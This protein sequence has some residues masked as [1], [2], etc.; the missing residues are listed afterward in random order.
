MIKIGCVSI[1]VSHPMGIAN[2]LRDNCMDMRYTYMWDKGFRKPEE[3]EW[4]VKHFG[5][6]AEVDEIKD[7]VDKVDVGFIHSC[8]WEKHLP[9]AMPFIEAGKPVYLDK[10]VVGTVADV[11]KVRELIAGGAKII[12][13]SSVRYA[14]E[15]QNF[16][17]QPVEQRGEVLAA[18]CT[19]GTNE[20]DY[21][22]HAVEALSEIAGAKAKS[23]K[24]VG[25]TKNAENQTCEAFTIEF[26]NGVVGTYYSVLGRYNPFHI[27]IVTTTQTVSFQINNGRIMR[28]LMVKVGHELTEGGAMVDMETLLNCTEIMLCGKKSRD[29]LNG[30]TVTIDM[31]SD[32]DKF[33]G[34]AFEADYGAKAKVSYKD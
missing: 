21:A 8:N 1:D 14:E 19:C 33:D 16:L 30:A 6:E 26:E 5:L 31:L 17:K 29:E 9:L 3:R 20:F 28:A 27:S 10:P 11:K 12:G 13:G 18:F 22:I 32:D 7:M 25:R 15:I 2:L 34:Y 4:F 24:F 23:A